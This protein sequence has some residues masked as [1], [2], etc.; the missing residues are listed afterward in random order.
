M[1]QGSGGLTAFVA[2]ICGS[3]GSSGALRPLTACGGTHDEQAGHYL[4]NMVAC[5]RPGTSDG[6]RAGATPG[7]RRDC[8][9]TGLKTAS[10]SSRA[11]FPGGR[12]HRSRGLVQRERGSVCSRA[13]YKSTRADDH[14]S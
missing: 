14:R 3:R 1:K 13:P 12:T 11:R 2:F 10:S 6:G 5:A 7:R 8:P 9:G 4:D